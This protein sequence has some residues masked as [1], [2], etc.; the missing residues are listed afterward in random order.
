MAGPAVSRSE[1]ERAL[2]Q[3]IQ[4]LRLPVPDREFRFAPPRRWRFDFAW[5][6]H[7]LAVEVEGGGFVG[8]RHGRGQGMAADAE[9]YN[10]AALLGWLVL[11][12]TPHQITS[13]MA[14]GW[15]ERGLALTALT[16]GG[17]NGTAVRVTGG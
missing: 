3:E 12:V 10:E 2:A 13:G 7:M 15:V 1:A 9:K 4:W 17:G 6:A 16:H 14:I 5:P 11:R 8:G